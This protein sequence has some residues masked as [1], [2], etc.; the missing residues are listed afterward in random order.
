[1]R[2]TVDIVCRN[3]ACGFVELNVQVEEDATVSCKVCH[4]L[5]EQKWWGTPTH[6][7]EWSD[8]DAVV[9]FR[10]PDGTYSFPARNDKPTP[11]GWERLTAKSDRQ[12]ARLEQMT[13]TLHQD[14]WYE[15]GSGRGFDDHF[16]GEKYD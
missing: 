1:M 15:K 9:I 11:P 2:R 8:R 3:E 12:V 6:N 13:N 4:E 10:K 16:R 14:R 5:A 7:A